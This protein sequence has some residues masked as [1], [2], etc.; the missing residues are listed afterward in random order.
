M[1]KRVYD[2]TKKKWVWPEN[3]TNSE[4]EKKLDPEERADLMLQYAKLH[5]ENSKEALKVAR[6]TNKLVLIIA[7]PFI[8]ALVITIGMLL[9]GGLAIGGL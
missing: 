7:I 5:Y 6:S 3:L 1:T 2:K 4:P 9:L 8:I